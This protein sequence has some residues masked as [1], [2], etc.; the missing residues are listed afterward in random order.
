M[1]RSLCLALRGSGRCALRSTA[2]RSQQQRRRLLS[3][4][5]TPARTSS[6]YDVVVVGGGV[7]GCSVAFHLKQ[8]DPSV[9]VCV[10]ERDPT[11]VRA[12]TPL[13]A[14]SIRQQFSIRGN[15]ELSLA[16]IDF[17]RMAGEHLKVRRL[18]RLDSAP[19]TKSLGAVSRCAR[20]RHLC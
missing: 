3:T 10:I 7:V 11:Y 14:G 5:A 18:S 15:V 13:S 6:S 1:Q 20:R 12:S 16:S 2:R 8:A 4:T 9:S 17:L 19:R